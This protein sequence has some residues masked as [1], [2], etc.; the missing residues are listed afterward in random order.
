MDLNLHEHSPATPG[1]PDPVTCR[2]LVTDRQE[3]LA[4][5]STS[6]D[7]VFNLAHLLDPPLL[8]VAGKKLKARAAAGIDRV[9]P[10]KYRKV[11]HSNINQLI[12]EVKHKTYQPSP[13]RR[14]SIPKD[15]GSKRHLGLPT[16]K[17]KHLQG[18]VRIL[19]E[20]IYEPNFHP[21][22]YGFRPKR[23]AQA[24]MKVMRTWMAQHGGAWM[25]E[26]DLSAFFDTIPHDQLLEVIREKVG[27]KTIL[28]L[29]KLWLQAG[30]M[31]DGIVQPAE[32]GTPQGGVIS[33]L[34][35]N[36][37]LNTVLDWWFFNH[38]LPGLQGDAFLVRY[39]DDFVIAFQ[40]EDDCRKALIDITARLEDYG[41]S[42]NQRK[43][44][45]TDMRIPV[46]GTSQP[47]NTIDFLGFTYYWKSCPDLGWD[48]G[49]RTSEKSIKRFKDRI[50]TWIATS[51]MDQDHLESTLQKKLQGHRGYFEVEGNDPGTYM[52]PGIAPGTGIGHPPIPL[53]FT[54]SPGIAPPYPT[55]D[56]GTR[57]HEDVPLSVHSVSTHMAALGLP[58]VTSFIFLVPAGAEIAA[59]LSHEATRL[60][61]NPLYSSPPR[62]AIT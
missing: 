55:A 34:A 56:D 54:L 38:Y 29:I 13:A 35:A 2:R 60:K 19:L 45:I 15:D 32:R 24:A 27:D 7:Q 53:S 17:D 10:R 9:T 6:H 25:L 22:S 31:V 47:G 12:T 33:P 30:T 4:K 61:S 23:S 40:D 51:E 18:A 36:I 8:F 28:K 62:Q 48:L 39:A 59:G 20:A 52:A 16:V 57:T 5:L 58:S 41:L 37:Y 11:L 14:V 44:K 43:T 46:T 21:Q 3:E 42:V 50:S 26:I 49:I 1:L